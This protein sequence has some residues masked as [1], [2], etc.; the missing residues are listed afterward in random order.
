MKSFLKILFVTLAIFVARRSD[1]AT[2]TGP[3]YLSYSN[4][5]YA[6]AVLIRP[7]STPL[8]L[9]PNLVTGGDFKVNTDANGT[10]SVDL[11]AGNYRVQVGADRPFVID[12]PTGSSTYTLLERITN[13]LSWN[14]SIIP[15]TNTST[16][17]I[18]AYTNIAQMV[19]ATVPTSSGN[20]VSVLGRST[21]NDGGGGF[22]MF[23]STSSISTN[24]GTV[25]AP[26]SGSGRWLRQFDGELN[27][28]WFGANPNHGDSTAAVRDALAFAQNPTYGWSKDAGE[29][30]AAPSIYVPPGAYDVSGTL[31]NYGVTFRGKAAQRAGNY[32]S[33]TIFFNKHNGPFMVFN[34]GGTT[35]GSGAND[36]RVGAVQ[37]MIVNG[38][39]ETYQTFKSITAVT[40]RTRFF[41]ATGDVP[42]LDMTSFPEMNWCFFY[43][44]EG[45]WLG[46]AQI[47]SVV[48]GT[49]EINLVS[50]TDVYA[51]VGGS[52]LRTSDKVVFSP[53]SAG[54]ENGI[55]S[56]VDP[57]G[58]GPT[59]FWIKSGYGGVGNGPRLSNV[60]INGFHVGIR[61]G[62]GVLERRQQGLKFLGNK[63]ADVL[64]PREFNST[65]SPW[66]GFTYMNGFYRADYGKT[67]TN[68]ISNV[69]LQNTTFGFFGIGPLERIEQ[70]L[71]EAHSYAQIAV[72]R[73]LS[74]HIDYAFLDL[75]IRHGLIVYRGYNSSSSSS[76]YDSTLSIGNLQVRSPLSTSGYYQPDPIHPTDRSAVYIPNTD[77]S[78]PV[79]LNIDQFSVSDGGGGDFQNGFD[80]ASAGS[81]KVFLGQVH[82]RNGSTTNWVKSGST[83]PT[84]GHVSAN[85]TAAE[86]GTGFITPAANQVTLALNG[87][88][89]VAVTGS[90]TTF[91]TQTATPAITI[92]RADTG[93]TY[94]WTAGTDTVVFNND[95]VSKPF[96]VNTSDASSSTLTL[97]QSG[98]SYT[99][100]NSILQG[101]L[102]AAGSG[103][104]VAPS[105]LYVIA[106]RGTGSNTGGGRV[107][108]NTPDS[109]ASGTGSQTT[110]TRLMLK[111]EGQLNFS[112]RA[113]DPTAAPGAGDLYYQTGVGFRWYNGTSWAT[114]GAGGG[115]GDVVGPSSAADNALVR[116]DTTTGKLVQNSATQLD[117]SGNLTLDA[118]A[119]LGWGS[120]NTNAPDTKLVRT[121][122]NV[123]SQR[124]GTSA[125]THRIYNTDDGAGNAEWGSIDWGTL[126]TLTLSTAASGTGAARPLQITGGTTVGITSSGGA[127]TIQPST[128]LQFRSNGANNRWQIPTTGH[129]QPNTA[130]ALDLGASGSEVR[131]GYFATSLVMSS[132][133]TLGWNADTFLVRA[134]A[135][136]LQQRNGVTAQ[137][138]DIANT[139]TDA[140]NY[141]VGSLW[142]T[143]NVLAIGSDKLGTGVARAVTFM[144][145][146]SGKWQIDTSG[147]FVPLVGGSLNFG[148]SSQRAASGFF[149]SGL[150][151]GASG[152]DV[153]ATAESLNV[154]Q[155]GTDAATTAAQTI[156]S[157]DGSGTD[158]D[159]SKLTRAGGKSTGTGRGGDL[160]DQTSLTGS[161]GSSQN[162][163]STRT[164]QS[165][166]YVDLT[167]ATATQLFTVTVGTGKY[168]G[169]QMVCTVN[170][171]DAT[172]FQAMTSTITFSAVNKAG[173]IT[174]GTVQQSDSAAAVS[175]GTLTPVTYT[176]T[177]NGSG[178]LGVKVAATSSLTQTVLRAKWQ[179][180]ALNS[181][182]VA[183]VTPN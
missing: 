51:T 83:K 125:Q 8:P 98:S 52:L 154:L 32:T 33:E 142:W 55:A 44:N 24:L 63:F 97:G 137:R 27:L 37:D 121:A 159:G 88:N 113:S 136:N 21:P 170:A 150:A 40:D 91:T 96:Q 147:N 146:G 151:I 179:I 157:P 180:D 116:F 153:I 155:L 6:G 133:A 58:A 74:Q 5:P 26:A 126:N 115:S 156:K 139:W 3:I 10:F 102:A 65:D 16:A 135:N 109:I 66:E 94:S 4:R 174:I 70:L 158:K 46:S 12:V 103:T 173:T 131:S 132:A 107:I 161:T 77:P 20:I 34:Y 163:Y 176:I 60:L 110:T 175:A 183:T 11:T 112:P 79:Y 80:I 7:L 48:G 85:L 177:D 160:I 56:F 68:T 140:S 42:T 9:T 99:P 165:A 143:G 141:E 130:N 43:S 89:A 59:C 28:L 167:E 178:V 124:N 81:S 84:I 47:S 64:F 25:F 29:T 87:T 104:D 61:V 38:Y 75:C 76:V 30:Y 172:D 18:I 134:A 106:P 101:E 111:R 119:Y 31:T 71:S 122:A 127:I 114:L 1:G 45:Q 69:S 95:S 36:Y 49:G 39:A 41:V 53:M 138:F 166:K 182:D 72:L 19:A 149:A 92:T 57:A 82:S 128:S 17:T 120:S 67:Y 169:L 22:F 162:N 2:I 148:S 108:F 164:Y 117:D 14:S 54:D 105:D 35:S 171:A 73:T 100:R 62:P 78:F 86:V 123:L 152:S 93:K 15:S 13:S 145:G 50:G 129:F 144:I 181:D 23:D 90:G 168:L 118:S